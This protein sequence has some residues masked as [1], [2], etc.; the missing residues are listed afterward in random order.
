VP[1]TIRNEALAEATR[2]CEQ[3]TP[4]DLRDQLRLECS[5]RG[6]AITIVERRAPWNPALGTDWSTLAIAQL[7]RDA[8]GAWS[9]HWRG[10]DARWHLYEE[11][12]PSRD[13]RPLLAE[14]D[15]DPTGIFWG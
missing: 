4:A 14:I 9:L 7:R 10:G 13:V 8:R 15:A 12:Q 5:A 6:S 11:V 3:R 1:M 2:F